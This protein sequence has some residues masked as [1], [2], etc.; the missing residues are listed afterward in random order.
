ML[1]IGKKCDIIHDLSIF[2]LATNYCKS[3]QIENVQELYN[4]EDDIKDK[5]KINFINYIT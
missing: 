4:Q 2:K 1:E 3:E 5:H